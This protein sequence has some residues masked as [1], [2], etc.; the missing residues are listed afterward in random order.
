MAFSEETK[1]QAWYR[2]VNA[3][4]SDADMVGAATPTLSNTPG[5]S[6]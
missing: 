4:G 6:Q 2:A 5:R 1:T 3:L